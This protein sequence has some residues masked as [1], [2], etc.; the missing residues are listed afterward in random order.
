MYAVVAPG[1]SCVYTNWRDVERIKKLYPY[2]KWV[3]VDSEEA[4]R[5]WLKRNTY[6][7]NLSTINK[8]GN[9]LDDLYVDA[10]YK[11]F[12]D[13]LC[14]VYDTSRVGEIRLPKSRN[15]IEYK[16]GKIYVRIPDIYLSEESIVGHM[17]ALFNLFKTV[18]DIVDVNVELPNYS[19]FYCLTGYSK[20]NQKSIFTVQN[21][22]RN[23]QGAVSYSV[24]LKYLRG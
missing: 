6:G 4:A 24:K 15:L 14:L 8:Y 12:K 5:E 18:G 20:G 11:I 19:I 23:R 16:P 9:T 3:K 7:H 21:L 10:K 2:P 13:C 17:S 22:I 1:L